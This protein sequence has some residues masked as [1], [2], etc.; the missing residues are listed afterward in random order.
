MGN[1]MSQTEAQ[2]LTED[3]KARIDLGDDSYSIADALKINRDGVREIILQRK[4]R[5]C[6]L[7]EGKGKRQDKGKDKICGGCDGLGAQD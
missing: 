6:E 4:S 5:L 2:K 7:C 3:V 1:I